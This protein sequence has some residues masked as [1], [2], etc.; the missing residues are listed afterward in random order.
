MEFFPLGIPTAFCNFIIIKFVCFLFCRLMGFAPAGPLRHSCA[1]A[2]QRRTDRSPLWWLLTRWAFRLVQAYSMRAEN[3]MD[4]IWKLL[5]EL[6]GAV[7]VPID[8]LQA[9]SSWK[10]V[11]LV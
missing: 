2:W 5:L 1:S 8:F 4:T 3:W 7:I 9:V 6:V 11:S 10:V